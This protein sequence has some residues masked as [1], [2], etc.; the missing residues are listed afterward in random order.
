MSLSFQR[1]TRAGALLVAGALALMAAMGWA[2]VPRSAT[3]APVAADAADSV[4]LRIV[5]VGGSVVVLAPVSVQGQG[6]YDFVLDTGA[7]RS[8]VD[9]QLAEE[10]GLARVAA[11]PQVSGVSGPAQATVVRVADW[12]A[13]DVTLPRGIVAAMDLQLSDSAAAQQL[14]GRRIYGLLG[15]DVL[16][17]FGVVTIDYE[18]QILTLGVR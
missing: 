4:P 15:S 6:P 2:A 11:V 10:L 17:S 1:R 18:Q 7:S 8:V 9:R 14:L 3:A 12:S 5:R 13:G 16:S